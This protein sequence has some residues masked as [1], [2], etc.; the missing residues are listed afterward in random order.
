M[1]HHDTFSVVINGNT[2]GFFE[3]AEDYD[4]GIHSPHTCLGFAW[5]T[6]SRSLAHST[7]RSDFH[8]HPMCEQLRIAH[9]MYADDLLLFSRGDASSVTQ[10]V[11]CLQRFAQMAGLTANLAKS[12]IYMAGIDETMRH[13]LLQITGFPVGGDAFQ[14]SGDP[15]CLSE[16]TDIRLYHTFGCSDQAS[17]FLA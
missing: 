13:R 8:F 9:L 6:L 16:A 15:H 1:R 4:R 5:S 17:H 10:L 7:V 12:S 3:V 2:Y 14:I 11:G